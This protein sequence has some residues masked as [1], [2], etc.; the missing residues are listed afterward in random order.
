MEQAA[1]LAALKAITDQV[2]ALTK[3]VMEKPAT[4]T[5]EQF[6]LRS[7]S[8][9]AAHPWFKDHPKEHWDMWGHKEGRPSMWPVPGAAP[10]VTPAPAPAP[11]TPPPEKYQYEPNGLLRTSKGVKV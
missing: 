4:E 6:Y 9:V 1:I 10:V 3:V 5:P 11:V 7:N 8:D 2:A